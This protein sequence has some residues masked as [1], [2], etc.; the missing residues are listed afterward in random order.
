MVTRAVQVSVGGASN[1][2]IQYEKIS[3]S[4]QNFWGVQL[5]GSNSKHFVIS[6]IP[7]I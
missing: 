1:R 5:N 3:Q 6:P 4:Y 7:I 2:Y